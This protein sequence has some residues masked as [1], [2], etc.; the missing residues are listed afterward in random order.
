MHRISLKTHEGLIV[1]PDVADA[2]DLVKIAAA[3]AGWQCKFVQPDPKPSALSLV[4][5]GREIWFTFEKDGASAQAALYAAWGCAVPLGFTPK[6]RDP[7]LEDGHMIY[8]YLGPWQA[9]YGKLLAE[10]R[11]HL[12]WPSVCCAAQVDVGKWEGDKVGP[13]FIQAQLHRM[14]RNAGPIDGVIG[15]RSAAAI[16]SLSLPRDSS[17]ADALKVAEPAT[18]PQSTVSRGHLHLPGRQ[19]VI[20]GFG[21]VKVWSM[22][23]GAGFEVSG[24]GRVVVDVR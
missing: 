1:T 9:L 2:M 6:L 4:P 5:A 15:Q 12:A 22:D 16:E 24:P 8:R 21:G 19:L 18:N 23:N 20:E 7:L 14:G 10:G 3:K 17:L 11:G 13:R